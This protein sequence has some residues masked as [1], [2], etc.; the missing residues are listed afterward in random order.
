[1][2]EYALWLL[3]FLTF[4]VG[5]GMKKQEDEHLT[6]SSS[7]ALIAEL[8]ISV[9]FHVLA[10][11]SILFIPSF[12]T[13]FMVFFRL[14]AQA[15]NEQSVVAVVQIVLL[16]LPT[17]LVISGV[18]MRYYFRLRVIALQSELQDRPRLSVA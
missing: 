17:P 4:L 6:A 12:Q 3:V 11:S 15:A 14:R 7:Y 13:R 18:G 1:M 8:V 5:T 10:Y 16:C 9:L 2:S